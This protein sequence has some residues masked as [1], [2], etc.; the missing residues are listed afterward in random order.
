MAEST[1]NEVARELLSQ[2]KADKVTWEDVGTWGTY[3]V[4]F[5]D[6]VLI[7]TRTRP[8]LEEESDLELELMNDAGRVIDSLEASPEDAMYAVLTE[9]FDLAEHHVRNTGI[10]KALDYLTQI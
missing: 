5:P 9:I 8:A 6:V 2:S 4:F 3:R 1:M 10:N 7:I